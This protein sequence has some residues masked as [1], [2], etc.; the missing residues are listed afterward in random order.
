MTLFFISKKKRKKNSGRSLLNQS[1]EGLCIC[2]SF[3]ESQDSIKEEKKN[4][5]QTF[6]IFF[7]HIGGH[8]QAV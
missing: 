7:Y 5:K 8:S 3:Q 2:V 1:K 4:Q 6:V